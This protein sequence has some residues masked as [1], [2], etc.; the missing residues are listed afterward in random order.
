MSEQP[1]KTSLA[2]LCGAGGGSVPVSR[3]LSEQVEQRQ[4]PEGW[5]VLGD[6][7]DII[8]SVEATLKRFS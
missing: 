4:H 5:V 1:L 8:S 2:R 7:L 6:I 3:A